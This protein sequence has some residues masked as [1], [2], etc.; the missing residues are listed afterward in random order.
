MGLAAFIGFFHTL[1]G[2]DHYVPFI[3][4]ARAG[5]WSQSKT[6]MVV[7][8]CGL[9]HVAGS[10]LLG[11]FGVGLGWAVE[12]LE[13]TESARAD[14]ASWLLLGFGLAYLLWGI[15]AAIRGTTHVH[16]HAHADGTVHAHP[17][18]HHGE[19]V[20]VHA[21]RLQGARVTPWVLFTIFIFGPCEPLIPIL[22]YPAAA[23]NTKAVVAVTIVFAAATLATMTGLV[24]LGSIRL[25]QASSSRLERYSQAGAGVAIIICGLTIKLGL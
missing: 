9:G 7:V 1:I 14:L 10:V 3:A 13:R 23:M 18:H 5:R 22:M 17:H 20:H 11:S 4:M 16:L 2:P 12:S 25:A 6:M 8:L 24:I 19:H 21:G 15:R